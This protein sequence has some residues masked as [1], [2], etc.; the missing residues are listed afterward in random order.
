M[1][2][3]RIWL[4]EVNRE[5]G[6][7]MALVFFAESSCSSYCGCSDQLSR[8]PMDIQ[9]DGCGMLQHLRRLG[10]VAVSADEDRVRRK[11]RTWLAC[12]V[13]P[14]TAS[15]GKDHQDKAERSH[16]ASPRSLCERKQWQEQ[17]R[18]GGKLFAYPCRS[19]CGLDRLDRQGEAVIAPPAEGRS[20]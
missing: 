5:P 13:N 9:S 4:P 16:E 8:Q 7:R 1:G 19:L 3:N 17:N 12:G 14:V 18:E 15:C 20:G 11:N 10:W 6:I 2:G